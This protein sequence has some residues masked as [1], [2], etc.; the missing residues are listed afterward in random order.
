[1][2]QKSV[3]FLAKNPTGE[4]N[5][6]VYEGG[7]DLK[8]AN[9]KSLLKKD[10]TRKNLSVYKGIIYCNSMNGNKNSKEADLFK[11]PSFAPICNP[12]ERGTFLDEYLFR[13]IEEY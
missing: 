13:N 7:C 5:L 3:L 10:G 6:N 9:G 8:D 4:E 2:I 12:G 1:M 11:L